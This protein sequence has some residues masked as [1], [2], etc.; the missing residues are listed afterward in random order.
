MLS[1]ESLDFFKK[2]VE[3]PSPSG[4]EQPAAKVFRDYVSKFSKVKVDVMGNSI[5]TLNEEAGLRIMLA[6]HI[7][8]IGFLVNYVN[9]QGFLYLTQAGGPNVLTLI[10]A[11]LKIHTKKGPILGVFGAKTKHQLEEEEAKKTYKLEDLWV[12]IGAKDKN[13]ALSMICVGDPVTFADGFEELLGGRVIA[14]GF[15]DKVGAFVVAE[16]LKNLANENLDA[17]VYGVATVQEELGLRGARTA[18]YGINP[19]VGIAI[20]VTF[21]NDYPGINKQKWG[22][23]DL[24][25]GPVI[26]RGG[27]INPKIY[28]TLVES[29]ER[30]QLPYQIDAQGSATGTD[31]NL[32]QVNKE[33]MATGLVSVPL[34]YM[35]SQC[36]IVS[37]DDV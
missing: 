1:K 34:R 9:D 8:Q 10:G 27:N 30:L 6:G 23:T 3:S 33:G 5:A 24:D 25:K 36:E 21:G 29:A 12:D 19:Q 4:F 26:S 11:R 32:M 13:D 28:D 18:A 16:V 20:D 35:H 37:L 31:A 17:A 14:P 2:L 22:E 15:D 7:D